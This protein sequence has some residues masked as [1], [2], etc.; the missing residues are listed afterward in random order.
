ML[1]IEK[2]ICL[3]NFLDV[4]RNKIDNAIKK[5]NK[6]YNTVLEREVDSSQLN[7]WFYETWNK[8]SF[9]KQIVVILLL[10]YYT[11]VY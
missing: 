11:C 9:L 3:N 2:L 7:L 10:S 5:I 1:H 4:K 6:L 8:Q